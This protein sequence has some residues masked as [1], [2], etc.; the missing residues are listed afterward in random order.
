MGKISMRTIDVLPRLNVPVGRVT[1]EAPPY[2][3]LDVTISALYAM[4]EHGDPRPYFEQA[5]PDYILRL[6]ELIESDETLPPSDT[7]TRELEQWLH[8]NAVS[9]PGEPRLISLLETWAAYVLDRFMLDVA[10]GAVYVEASNSNFTLKTV[11]H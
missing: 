2:A 11:V 10:A 8:A 4:A 3:C 5:P 1:S 7:D 6:H 9:N